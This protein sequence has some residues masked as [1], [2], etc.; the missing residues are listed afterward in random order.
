MINQSCP[1]VPVL[2]GLHAHL[3]V[4]IKAKELGM[5]KVL[6]VY[7][8]GV[9]NAGIVDPVIES[10]RTSRIE[11][12]TFDKVTP[13]PPDYQVDEGGKLANEE[14]VDGIVAIGGGSVLDC[15]KA[16]NYLTANPA[17][18]NQWFF[19]IVPQGEPLPMIAIPTT[20]GTGSEGSF[21]AV[22]TDS[23]TGI[24][25]ALLDDRF[26][27]FSLAIA[28]PL[29]YAGL[30]SKPSAYCGFDVLTH[31]IDSLFSAYDEP[32]AHMF[33]ETAIR[34]T[35]KYLPRVI[36]YGKDYEA[37]QEIAFSATIAGNLLNTNMAG[38]THCMG[39]SIGAVCHLAH[40]LA[41]ALPLV[42]LMK[43]F[44]AKWRPERAQLIGECFGVQ[45]K[46]NESPA[47]I[48]EM[49]GNAIHKFYRN[50]GIETLSELNLKEE[51]LE[52]ALKMMTADIQTPTTYM[53]MSRSDYQ[54]VLDHMK[55]L[56]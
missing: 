12:V 25:G 27:R 42:S 4:G 1:I 43:L 51:D 44:Y 54:S 40:G 47:E 23:S 7:D 20:A 33:A 5:N 9:Y 24:K 53:L 52:T 17:P 35:I 30:P 3:R 36:T 41:V 32:Y 37:R 18:I 49:T 15:A 29:M 11:V 26:C 8:L 28:D 2:S 31:S 55:T 46:G 48:G 39:H 14:K 50:C 19:P 10:L 22:I 38:N 56:I 16:I 6:V 21:A 34:K 13:D 45:F